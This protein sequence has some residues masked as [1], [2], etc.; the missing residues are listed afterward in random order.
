MISFFVF[1]KKK[2]KKQIFC[3]PRLRKYIFVL[4]YYDFFLFSVF[5]A[6]FLKKKIFPPDGRYL[7]SKGDNISLSLSLG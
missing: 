1:L 2:Q 3:L 4:Q 6:F 7:A 5:L